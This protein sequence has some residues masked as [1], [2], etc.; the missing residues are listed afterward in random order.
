VS[1]AQGICY[2]VS[3]IIT[4]LVIIRIAELIRV[5]MLPDKSEE[6]DKIFGKRWRDL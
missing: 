1:I 3:P 6:M 5:W 2:T 4:I